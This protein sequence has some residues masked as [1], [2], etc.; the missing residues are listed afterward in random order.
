VAAALFNA[1]TILAAVS[2][3]TPVAV[4]VAEQRILGRKTG[5]NIAALTGA[6][7]LAILTMQA[8]ADFNF[9]LR[10]IL[11][12]AAAT[13]NTSA[14]RFTDVNKAITSG[15][16]GVVAAANDTADFLAMVPR[17]AKFVITHV[18]VSFKVA[19]TVQVTIQPRLDTAGLSAAP[20][21]ANLSAETAVVAANN[22]G[23]L[24][25]LATPVTVSDSNRLGF[26]VTGAGANG[27]NI[28]VMF[29]GYQAI[30]TP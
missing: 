23:V 16:T 19:P 14:A 5:G 20:S 3:D 18:Y 30:T 6:E 10:E 24:K 28:L 25:T 13:M 11:S 27:E 26:S 12:I 1:Q 22:Y 2:D 15:K 9:N 29:V 8:A 7:I 17:P 4:T 21:W